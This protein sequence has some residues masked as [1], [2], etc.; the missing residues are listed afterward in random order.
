[1]FMML[2]LLLLFALLEQLH[3]LLEVLLQALIH[4]PTCYALNHRLIL[5][6][7]LDILLIDSIR[8]LADGLLSLNFLDLA[9][10][11]PLQLINLR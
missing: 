7:Q 2:A 4:L 1:M 11:H 8:N 6:L 9:D 10:D 5:P 3:L